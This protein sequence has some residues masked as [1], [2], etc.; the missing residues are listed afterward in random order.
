LAIRFYA[1]SPIDR[2][3]LL[4]NEIALYGGSDGMYFYTALATLWKNTLKVGGQMVFEAGYDTYSKIISLFSN[5]GYQN[6]K[7]KADLNKIPRVVA[8]TKGNI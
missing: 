3:Y 5:Q 6:V 1:P 7:T 8:A 4:N 2:T